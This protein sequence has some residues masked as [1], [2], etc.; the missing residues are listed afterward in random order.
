MTMSAMSAMGGSND[1]VAPPDD[2]DELQSGLGRGLGD[3]LGPTGA[4]TD[5]DGPG[6][7]GALFGTPRLEPGDTSTPAPTRGARRPLTDT[8]PA[9]PPLPLLPREARRA[10]AVHPASAPRFEAVERQLEELVADLDVDVAVHLCPGPAGDRLTLVRPEP[11]R[12]TPAQMDELCGAI[13]GFVAEGRLTTDDFA[14]A[15]HHC[16]AFGPRPLTDAGVYV[17]GRRDGFLTM[18]ERWAVHRHLVPAALPA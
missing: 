17:L 5:D 12:L 6:P 7:L 1:D 8:D 10:R 9:P 15:G 13:R 4:T 18:D 16:V 14:A 2:D 11:G 3:I